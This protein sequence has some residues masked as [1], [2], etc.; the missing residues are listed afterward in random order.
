MNKKYTDKILRRIRADYQSRMDA[1]EKGKWRT[2]E[3][4]DHIHFNENGVLDKAN[5]YVAKKMVESKS[6]KPTQELRKK[7]NESVKNEGKEPKKSELDT[8]RLSDKTT[9]SKGTSF[10]KLKNGAKYSKALEIAEKTALEDEEK[11]W[12][13]PGTWENIVANLKDEDIVYQKNEKGETFA[14]IPGLASKVDSEI[15]GSERMKKVFEGAVADEKKITKDLFDSVGN[16]G[17]YLDGTENASKGASHIE[18]KALRKLEKFRAETGNPEATVDDVA[19]KFG[20]LVRYTAMCDNKDIVGCVNKLQKNLSDQGYEVIELDNK[21]LGKDGKV[22]ED[23]IYRA[24]HLSVKAPSGRVFELQVHSPQS[25]A[26]K[27]LNHKEYE[28]QRDYEKTPK[29]EWTQEM[30]DKNEELNKVQIERWRENYKNPPGIEKL[31]PFKR[32]NN[33]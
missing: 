30:R 20:D 33:P 15:K 12:I 2:T 18:D 31:K 5:P 29:D 10:P 3:E 6:V 17:M 24:V 16:A 14:C 28:I 21:F 4:G 32:R 7:V 1:Q 8:N 13:K 9:T 23:A 19:E 27:D 11:G 25:Q 22:N 26:V